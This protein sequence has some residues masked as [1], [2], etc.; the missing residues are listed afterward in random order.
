M[1]VIN[2]IF[3]SQRLLLLCFEAHLHTDQFNEYGTTLV[4]LP[5]LFLA[6]N[7]NLGWTHTVNTL[8]AADRYELTLQNDGYLL[9]GQ[10]IPFEK[11]TVTIKVKESNGTLTEQKMEIKISKQGPVLSEKDNKAIVFRIAGLENE[12]IFEEYDKMGKAKNLAEFEA[13]LK[14]L[15]I[16]MFNVIYADKA[17]NIFYLFNGNIPKRPEGDF[18]FWRGI[19]DGTKSKLI[20][21]ETLHYRG[22]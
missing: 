1:L 13:A 12:K 2:P 9:D 15:Q 3:M 10:T 18:R 4:G 16:P 7:D 11:R 8:D 17:G 20:W 14:M 19:V 22:Y 5:I 6:F 21:Q